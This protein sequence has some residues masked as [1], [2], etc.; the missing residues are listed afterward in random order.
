M[1]TTLKT[2]TYLVGAIKQ[3]AKTWKVTPNNIIERDTLAAGSGIVQVNAKPSGLSI[4][5]IP[6]CA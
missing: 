1:S 4:N 2:L 5:K 3:T 6:C